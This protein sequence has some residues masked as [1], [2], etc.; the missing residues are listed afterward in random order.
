MLTNWIDDDGVKWAQRV[1]IGDGMTKR[2]GIRPTGQPF[3][4][5]DPSY[6][7]RRTRKKYM[8]DT[9]ARM[10]TACEKIA[11]WSLFGIVASIIGVIVG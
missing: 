1:E 3:K 8:H 2:P 6:R 7:K 9:D 10:A 5:N 4:V 11:R